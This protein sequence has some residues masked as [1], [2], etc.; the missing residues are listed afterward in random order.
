MAEQF[1][2]MSP[3][4]VREQKMRDKMGQAADKARENSLGKADKPGK[5]S[6]LEKAVSYPARVAVLGGAAAGAAGDQFL[7]NQGVRSDKDTETTKQGKGYEKAKKLGRMAVG[8]DSLDEE[9]AMK[10][11]GKVKKMAGGTI[12]NVDYVKQ[13]AGGMHH[14]DI[15]KKEAAG[16]NAHHEYIKEFGK[17]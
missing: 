4:D 2:S 15:Y 1:K 9:P 8:I 6:M 11:G 10:K 16:H 13:T 5:M 7:Y 12:H 14:S 17:K 3:E